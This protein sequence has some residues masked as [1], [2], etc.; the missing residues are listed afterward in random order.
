MMTVEQRNLCDEIAKRYSPEQMRALEK[1]FVPDI[2][3][4]SIID[5]AV[6]DRKIFAVIVARPD[7]PTNV[8][9]ALFAYHWDVDPTEPTLY[10]TKA[11]DAEL[12]DFAM[13]MSANNPQLKGVKTFHEIGRLAR[14]DVYVLTPVV[15]VKIRTDEEKNDAV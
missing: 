15:V 12:Y 9:A 2:Y 8:L 6:V 11:F 10:T 4:A 7:V 14:V 5:L 13:P 1:A 3:F